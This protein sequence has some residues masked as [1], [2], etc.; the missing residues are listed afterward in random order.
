MHLLY[1]AFSLRLSDYQSLPFYLHMHKTRLQFQTP[2]LLLQAVAALGSVAE[3]T[4][5]RS[6]TTS[7]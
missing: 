1:T 3:T 7:K 4:L 5:P 2:S 6:K